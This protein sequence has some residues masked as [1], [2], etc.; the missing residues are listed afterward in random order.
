VAI[1]RAKQWRLDH[2]EEHREYSRLWKLEHPNERKDQNKLYRDRH[3]EKAKAHKVVHKAVSDGKIPSPTKMICA[4]C[5]GNAQEY[6][7]PDYS[8]P[9]EVIALCRVCHNKRHPK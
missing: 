4:D 7:H 5:E 1:E 6:H 9:L 2:T 3:P 8:K